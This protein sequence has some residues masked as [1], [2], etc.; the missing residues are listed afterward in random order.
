MATNNTNTIRV[1]KA[2][3]YN[4]AIALLEGKSPVVLP[5]KDDKAGVTM[6]AEYLCEFFRGELALLSKKNKAGGTKKLTP[7]QKK[8]E[9]Y[10]DDI[11]AF[12]SLN[13]N[14]LVSANDLMVKLF[15]SKY[16]GVPW[17]NQ[18][19]ASLLNAMA[20][21]LGK[22]GT[23]T[24]DSGELFKTPAKG[25]NKTLYQIKPEYVI[26]VEAEAEDADEGDV[27][28]EDEA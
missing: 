1:T 6:D 17:T 3:K 2:Q 22:D 15:M 10:K 5:G 12:L 21:K 24:D 26:P 18:K 25:K 11:R 27:E 23:V 20:D 16:P 28:D 4:A 7:D 19:V 14:L 13:P 8:N 9:E